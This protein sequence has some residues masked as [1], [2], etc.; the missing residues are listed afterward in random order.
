MRT[1]SEAIKFKGDWRPYQ[2]RVL[3]DLQS[4]MADKK[5]H[6]VAAPGSGKTTVGLEIIRR[7][8]HP[9]LILTP[10]ITIREQWVERFCSGFLPD[11]EDPLKWVSNSMK[12]PKPITAVTYQALHSAYKQLTDTLEEEE[13]TGKETADFADF[14]LIGTLKTAGIKTICLDEAH[15]LRNEWWKALEMVSE[16]LGEDLVTVSLTATPPYDATPSEWQRYMKMCGEFDAEIFIPELVK[17]NNLCP[18]QDYV[19][20]NWPDKDEL[21]Q[22]RE[23]KESAYDAA[24]EIAED[25]EFIQ[26]ISSHPGISHVDDYAEL[27][28]DQ[29]QYLTAL[30]VFLTSNG[31][32]LPK[33]FRTLIGTGDKPPKLSIAWMEVLLQCFLYEDCASYPTYGNLRERL[34]EKLKRLGHIQRKK[35]AL[36][37]SKAINKLLVSSKGKRNSIYNIVRSEYGALSGRLRL[38]ILT[39]FIKKEMPDRKSVV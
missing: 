32:E 13:L 10:S 24:Y 27:F 28:L 14:D 6:I 9:C 15:H 34:F 1:F 19:F 5:V 35:V 2:K 16:A 25:P 17:V 33:E 38:L 12:A 36:T 37:G 11:G 39:D 4:C 22:I 29:P 23:F 26:A 30:I 20:F 18:H 8:D 31:I 7:L 3:E 21:S